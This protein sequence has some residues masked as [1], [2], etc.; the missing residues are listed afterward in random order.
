MKKK[1]ENDDYV[2]IEDIADK[3][4]L[5]L[6]AT[7]AEIL[8]IPKEEFD[9]HRQELASQKKLLTW[10]SGFVVAALLT[11]FLAFISF[12]IDAWRFHSD[13]KAKLIEELRSNKEALLTKEIEILKGRL[14]H[15]E[16]DQRSS[17]VPSST[18][19]EK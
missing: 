9:R 15:I 5:E 13:T 7:G 3:S 14:E 2:K 1:Q 17:A 12:A 16:S 6:N 11:C 10:T 18:P 8:I 4:S 19:E